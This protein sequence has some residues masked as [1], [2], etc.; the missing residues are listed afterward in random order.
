VL[1]GR[2]I[3][4]T[5]ASLAA[6]GAKSLYISCDVTD[7]EDTAR[8]CA[9]IRDAL[10]PITGI[11]HGAGVLADKRLTHK[12]EE[13]FQRVFDTKVEGLRS[14][15]AATE[16]DALT[17]LTLFSSV[18][19]RAGNPGQADYAMANE[20]LNRVAHVEARRR[21]KT[22]RVRT[23]NWGPWNDG[24]VTPQ[25]AAHFRAAGVTLIPTYVGACAFVAELGTGRSGA[26]ETVIGGG[27]PASALSGDA[28]R[29]VR[30][31]MEIDAHTHPQLA[32]HSIDGVPV[33]PLVLVQEWF[34]RA[35]GMFGGSDLVQVDLQV[36]SGVPLED[37]DDRPQRFVIACQQT[38]DS[39]S[40]ALHDHHD[41]V[42]YQARLE[43]DTAIT[44]E[45]PEPRSFVD[46]GPSSA[47]L[48]EGPLFHGPEFVAILD[49]HGLDQ[50]GA[51][52]TLQGTEALKWPEEPWCTDPLMLDGGLQMLRVWG[53][54]QLGRPTLPTS[55]GRFVRHQDGLAKGHVEC[56][57]VAEKIGR[58]GLRG[59]V[60]FLDTEGRLIAEM[61]RV[62]MHVAQASQA[63]TQALEKTGG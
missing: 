5:L 55:V 3:R 36:I 57:I 30:F 9:E 53:F 62:E 26:V 42:R 6:L 15:L 14:L 39:V 10:G 35:A 45:P 18:A 13:Q 8:A 49:L 43:P 24:M 7:A 51:A 21:G 54:D 38:G 37:F 33:L 23:I 50:G 29:E 32:S 19:A 25:L 31:L 22:C 16:A 11:V 58:L 63:T 4:A 1:A 20:V 48:Y 34:Q 44:A 56:R 46:G 28:P 41:K 59:S 40:L 52:G 12:T 2:E 47:G 61:T 60:W 17:T 27:D